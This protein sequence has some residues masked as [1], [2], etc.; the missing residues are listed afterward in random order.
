IPYP[1]AGAKLAS[2]T[3]HI[4]ALAAFSVDNETEI[5]AIVQFRSPPL[6]N[7]RSFKDKSRTARLQ[8]AISPA[9][10]DHRQFKSDLPAIEATLRA[11][12]RV[13]FSA[14]N[15]TIRYEYLTALNGVAITASRRVLDEISKLP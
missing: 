2:L 4:R 1:P 10:A 11:Q 7:L 8:S 12:S 3:E 15:A 13:P 5:N 9:R 6:S 14:P